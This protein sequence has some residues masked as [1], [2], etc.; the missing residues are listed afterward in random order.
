MRLSTLIVALVALGPAACATDT[1]DADLGNEDGKGDGTGGRVQI[2][3]A[4]FTAQVGREVSFAFVYSNQPGLARDTFT[5]RS[6]LPKIDADGGFT[7]DRP[8]GSAKPFKLLVFIDVDGA[9]GCSASDYFA[10]V[11]V[12]EG[13]ANAELEISPLQLPKLEELPQELLDCNQAF[14]PQYNATVSVSGLTGVD[15][16]AMHVFS[17][18]HPG[19]SRVTKGSVAIQSGAASFVAAKALTAGYREKLVVYVD[20]DGQPGCSESDL[21]AAFT[22][23]PATGP[24]QLTLSP[25]NLPRSPDP[26]E[27]LHDCN[28]FKGPAGTGDYDLIV[29]GSGFDAQNG[30]QAKLGSFKAALQSATIAGGAFE[31]VLPD[32]LWEA[33]QEGIVLLVDSNGDGRCGGASD[34]S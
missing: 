27:D 21:I 17:L 16:Q 2:T 13:S 25:G 31:V 7:I 14:S 15:G 19:Y 10:S 6:E 3:G 5:S 33:E 29:R 32:Y 23:D 1:D 12:P 26:A 24:Q 9:A 22:I 30:Q 20:K 18:P 4:G 11:Q 8:R 34:L 28:K